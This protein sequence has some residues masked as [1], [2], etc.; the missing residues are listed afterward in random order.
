M[1]GLK[2]QRD[3]EEHSGQKW[4]QAL[5]SVVEEKRIDMTLSMLKNLSYVEYKYFLSRL[6]SRFFTES[7]T[8]P[9][10]EDLRKSFAVMT[11]SHYKIEYSSRD[12]L[13]QSLLSKLYTHPEILDKITAQFGNAEPQSDAQDPAATEVVPEQKVVEKL[14]FEVEMTAFDSTKKI[15]IIKEIKSM[16]GLGLKEAKEFVEK[17]P[18]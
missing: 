4:N 17:C 13:K 3:Q 1:K 10:L 15:K 18:S 8:D 5:P 11:A 16:L 2:T 12:S 9:E 14:T 6:T 7:S